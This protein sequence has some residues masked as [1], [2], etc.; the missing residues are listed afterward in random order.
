MPTSST[1]STTTTATTATAPLAPYHQQDSDH[2]CGPA[3]AQMIL[4]PLHVTTLPPGTLLQQGAINAKFQQFPQ[5][6]E[7]C[8]LSGGTSPAAMAFGLNSYNNSQHV[9]FADYYDG[10]SAAAVLKI[11]TTLDANVAAAAL[12]LGGQHWVAVT[13]KTM[14]A[15]TPAAIATVTINN[16]APVLP[17][18]SILP[19]VGAAPGHTPTDG[20]SNGGPPTIS[21][22]ATAINGRGAI[23]HFTL[24]AWL[25]TYFYPCTKCALPPP[26]KP[27][28]KP[29]SAPPNLPHPLY[30]TVG[31]AG[32]QPST[33]ARGAAP[34]D[35]TV[36][37][38]APQASRLAAP[39]AS[40][41]ARSVAG[42]VAD[43]GET[44][45]PAVDPRDVL[46]AARRG[47]EQYQLAG[48]L[49][50]V[51]SQPPRLVQRTDRVD[52]FYYLVPIEFDGGFT[53]VADVDAHTVVYAGAQIRPLPGYR[54][55][56]ESTA[57]KCLTSVKDFAADSDSFDVQPTLAWLPCKESASPFSPFVKVTRHGLPFAFVGLDGTVY[58]QLH[59]L[60]SGDALPT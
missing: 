3:V 7:R 5:S 46:A 51:S 30:I 21:G 8:F 34:P 39:G 4:A 16:P 28:V 15:T 57:R 19:T 52:E 13:A 35:T 47:I 45:I 36:P 20:C 48:G 2:F 38:D 54:F 9:K 53:V 12:V 10:S 58:S 26:K 41:A 37:D 59:D 33:V 25:T 29:P 60:L 50:E 44:L 23:E 18:L 11:G 1:T 32:L 17:S 14:S 31:I 55:I 56:D 49:Y 42:S 6:D 40:P 43:A 27:P 22:A 24:A